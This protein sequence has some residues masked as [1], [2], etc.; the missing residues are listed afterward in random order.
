MSLKVKHPNSEL[1]HIRDTLTDMVGVVG[2]TRQDVKAI[3]QHQSEHDKR[4]DNHDKRFDN[5]DKRF[6]NHDKRFDNHDKRFDKIEETLTLILS[7]L[8]ANQ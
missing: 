6:D 7:R 5:H 4:F 8:P 2:E 3:K 1:D